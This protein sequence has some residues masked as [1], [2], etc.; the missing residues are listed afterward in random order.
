M[1]VAARL[2]LAALLLLA[3]AVWAQDTCTFPAETCN[4]TAICTESCSGAIS[5]TG[6]DSTCDNQDHFVIPSG[7][8]I[9][10]TAD[11]TGAASSELLVESGGT[12]TLEPGI[13]ATFDDLDVNAGGAI[14]G[15]PFYLEFGVA[16]AGNAT[17]PQKWVAGDVQVCP[18]TPGT[19]DLTNGSDCNN[20]TAA[21]SNANLVTFAYGQTK[22][23]QDG[24]AELADTFSNL[25]NCESLEC[26]AHFYDFTPGTSDAPREELYRYTITDVDSTANDFGFTID[27]N[28]G[29]L[30]TIGHGHPTD[31]PDHSQ[32]MSTQMTLTAALT[33]SHPRQATREARGASVGERCAC[34]DLSTNSADAFWKST[35]GIDQDNP[36]HN[37]CYGITTTTTEGELCDNIGIGYWLHVDNAV[38]DSTS[39]DGLIT[40][41]PQKIS[42]VDTEDTRGDDPCNANE[43][44]ICI[45]DNRGFQVPMPVGAVVYTSLPGFAPAD[46]FW[47]AQVP[48]FE[49]VT[50]EQSDTWDLAGTVDLTGVTFRKTPPLVVTGSVTAFDVWLEDTTH[51]NPNT[52]FVLEWEPSNDAPIDYVQVTGGSTIETCDHTAKTGVGTG[53]DSCATL[54]GV[55]ARG[56]A[57]ERYALTSGAFRHMQDR[58]VMVDDA[59]CGDCGWST[60]G[61]L[62]AQHANN[63]SFQSMAVNWSGA[64]ADPAF[65]QVECTNC[66]TGADSTGFDASTAFNADSGAAPAF[67]GGLMLWSVLGGTATSSEFDSATILNAIGIGLESRLTTSSAPFFFRA[68]T[69]QNVVIRDSSIEN[70]A[71][72]TLMLRADTLLKNGLFTNV[73][74]EAGAGSN[75]RFIEMRP[76][77]TIDGTAFVD[78]TLN[79]SGCTECSVLD[80]V[81]GASADN[82]LLNSTFAWADSTQHDNLDYGVLFAAAATGTFEGDGVLVTGFGGDRAVHTASDLYWSNQ[83]QGE[84]CVF[85]NADDIG[86]AASS[87]AGKQGALAATLFENVLRSHVKPV[88]F[89]AGKTV[90]CGAQ[91]RAGVCVKKR[92]HWWSGIEATDC[93]SSTGAGGGGGA[94]GPRGF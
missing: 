37:P 91:G 72:A 24:G 54:Q 92:I 68:D 67:N 94:R 8:A 23:N 5:C 81:I 39:S 20:A 82:A 28:Q 32:R 21:N 56:D 61:K 50:Q 69:I 66:A 3:P 47:V 26:V 52:A 63:E 36:T 9:T 93:S 4:W 35:N 76:S 42:D 31:F 46:P 30:N 60:I 44:A 58:A 75:N 38:G 80:W 14:S 15:T 65:D 48:V 62:R 77:Q 6:G 2:L 51:N 86:T 74:F 78:M 83:T 84:W 70:A 33:G 25:E 45:G 1:Q 7:A 88:P 53:D 22:W 71:A 11:V 49:A 79:S 89:T 34:F 18:A 55:A 17:T 12:L 40:S 16:S 73:I 19:V 41:A 59:D 13:T 57:G 85:D 43:V 27:A 90:P 29:T 64:E 10:I 87:F